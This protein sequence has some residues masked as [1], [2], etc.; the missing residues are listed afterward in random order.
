MEELVS[1]A[2]I[3]TFFTCKECG[4]GFP[5]QELLIIHLQ[6]HGRVVLPAPPEPK[7]TPLKK[8]VCPE[9]GVGF[10]QK[11]GLSQH[12]T[13][14][15]KSK[16]PTATVSVPPQ[17]M[18]HPHHMQLQP[19]TSSAVPGVPGAIM[20]HAR[21]HLLAEHHRGKMHWSEWFEFV[22]NGS[23]VRWWYIFL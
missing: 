2:K 14:K 16:A 7:P 18:P 9:C 20:N 3:H 6:Q 10:A 13:R 5:S 12:I 11:H 22:E 1:H 23:F 15:H 8:H 21:N 4:C 17:A 19:G